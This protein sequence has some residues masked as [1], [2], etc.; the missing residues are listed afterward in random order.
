MAEIQLILLRPQDIDYA[1]QYIGPWVVQAIGNE[2][3]FMDVEYIKDKARM[4]NCLIWVGHSPPYSDPNNI[5]VVLICEVAFYCN[6]RTLI[7]R[8]LSG[9]NMENWFH[10]LDQLELWASRSGFLRMEV[11]GREGWKR[12]LKSHGYAHEYTHLA[13]FLRGRVN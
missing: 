11:W 3:A 9:K 12:M 5:E 4:G 1:W 2:A 8:W 7:L 10:H 13:K 6:I